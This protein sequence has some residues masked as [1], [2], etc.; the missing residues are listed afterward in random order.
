[1]RHTTTFGAVGVLGVTLALLLAACGGG[2][3]DQRADDGP[4]AA[5]STTAAGAD[6]AEPREA[7]STDPAAAGDGATGIDASIPMPTPGPL[8]GRLFGDDLLV[9]GQDTLDP[10]VVAQVEALDGVEAVEQFSLAPVAVEDRVIDVAAVDP[11]TYRRFNP[12]N[13]AQFGEIWDRVARGEMGILPRLGRS[14]QDDEGFVRLGNDRD[15]PRVH[16][17]AYAPQVRQ[18]DGV[19]NENWVD[20]LGMRRDNALLVNTGSAAPQEV[21]D[22]IRELVGEGTPVQILGPDLDITATQTAFLSGG[23]VA[24]AVGTFSYRVIGGGR[25][26]PDPAWVEENIRTEEVPILGAVTCHKVMLPQLRA[27]FT[28]VVTRG[29]ADEINPDEYAGCYYPRFIAGSSSLSL[30]SFGIAVDL[31]VPGNQRGTVGDI[32]RDVVAIMKK[33]GFAW[34]GDWSFTDPMHFEMDR[35][36]EA[37]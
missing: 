13:A 21:R 35:L 29:L 32:D 19:V 22:P 8:E 16:I 17:G 18:I 5:S 12:V 6:E 1:M 3:G 26:A 23:S 37:R 7:P 27:A 25:I 30:H 15:A 28:E 10:D 34:G 36:V 9:Y 2:T 31:N 20:P 33:W 11:A 4:S 14:V 24:D